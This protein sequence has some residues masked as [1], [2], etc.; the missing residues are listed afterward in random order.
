MTNHL[1]KII[2]FGAK[3]RHVRARVT[4]NGELIRTLVVLRR[5]R[6]GDDGPRAA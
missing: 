1:A 3:R 2:P 5:P 6:E 4:A